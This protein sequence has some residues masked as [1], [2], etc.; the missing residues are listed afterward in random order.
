MTRCA[1]HLAEWNKLRRR[2]VTL[3]TAVTQ[4]VRDGVK[5]LGKK[6]RITNF[7]GDESACRKKEA[8]RALCLLFAGLRLP[9]H[10]ADHVLFRNAVSAIARAG[11]SYVPPKRK[12][13]GGPACAT[14]APV[15]RPRW[16]PSPAAGGGAASPLL[17]I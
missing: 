12:Y 6:G 7:F 10:H 8:D 5:A 3:C 4:D 9:E 17:A 11:T 13:I 14:A 15:S 2:D 1:Q 16:F